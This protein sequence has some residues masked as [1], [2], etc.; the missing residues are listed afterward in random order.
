MTDAATTSHPL[1]ESTARCHDLPELLEHEGGELVLSFPDGS[2]DRVVAAVAARQAPGVVL[3]E[4]IDG[5]WCALKLD[6]EGRVGSVTSRAGI[7]LRVGVAWLGEV[8]R[9]QLPGWTMIG[10][11]EAGT[12]WAAQE[13]QAEED[14]GGDARVPRFYLYAAF[15]RQGRRVPE[16]RVRR[17][18]GWVGH[19]RLV[20]VRQAAPGED[21]AAFTRRVLDRGGEGV[22]LRYP[23]GSCFRAKPR[24]TCDRYIS[25]VYYAPDRYGQQRLHADLSVV[26]GR[27]WRRVQQVLVPEGLTPAA[28]RRRVVVVVGASVHPRTG[29]VRHARIAAVREPGDKSPRECLV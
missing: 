25:R 23:D 12:H 24:L 1:Y 16:A 28:L 10:E 3:Q 20:A 6:E 11:L 19:P 27:G 2:I 21:W 15:D 17:L 22:V 5:C 9:W 29:V 4:K 13:R 7:P 18:P 8:V 14:E 26:R